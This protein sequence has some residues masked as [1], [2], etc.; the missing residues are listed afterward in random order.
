VAIRDPRRGYVLLLT[1]AVLFG[2]TGPVGK[3]ILEA[4]IEPARLAALRNTGSAVGLTIV[5]AFGGRRRFRVER[6]E[7]PALIVVGLC[8]AALIQWCYFVAVDRL[9]IGIAL[10]L[11]FTAP[12]L[13]ALYSRFVLRDILP[14]RVWLGLTAALIGLA[15]VAQV[16]GGGDGLDPVGVAAGLAAA[17][18]LATFYLVGKHSLASRD[19]ISVSWW[20]FVVASV[21]WAV[22]EPWWQFDAGVLREQVSLLGTFADVFVPLWAPVLWII[23]LGTLLPYALTMAALHHLTPT[24][25]GIVGMVEPVVATAVAWAWLSQALSPT[26]I[27]GG[28]L[29]LVAVGIVQASTAAGT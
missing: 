8:G 17:G 5:L 4:G 22:V 10:L 19:P 15:L 7:I 9:P 6:R 16:G 2:M 29:V 1:G 26:Q 14:R 13:V 25:T 23:V 20:M 27:A 28:V 24:T 3:V 18:F 11:E 12:V 21:F